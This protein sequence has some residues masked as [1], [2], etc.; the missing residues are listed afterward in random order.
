[1]ELNELYTELIL[2]HNQNRENKRH[3]EGATHAEHGHNPSCGDEITVEAILRAGR[4][5]DLAYTGAGCAISQASASM[6]ADLVKGR[7]V[8]EGLEAAQRFIGMI[9]REPIP[10]AELE[11]LGDAYILK[12]IQNIPA[13]VKC[14]VLAW[15]A[16]AQLLKQDLAIQG[17]NEKAKAAGKSSRNKQQA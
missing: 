17:E 7:T 15:H 13:R 16:L 11:E 14:A 1:M 8:Q 10:E 9:K 12:N 6:M 4:I 2:E 3:I 5:E